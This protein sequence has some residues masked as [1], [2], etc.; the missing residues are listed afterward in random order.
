MCNPKHR[1]KISRN[2]FTEV[3][4][5]GRSRRSSGGRYNA[6]KIRIRPRICCGRG[7]VAKKDQGNPWSPCRAITTFGPQF[8]R[9]AWVVEM[10]SGLR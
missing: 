1:S 5:S 8:F 4:V 3:V 7:A 6:L 9:I 2:V 10:T